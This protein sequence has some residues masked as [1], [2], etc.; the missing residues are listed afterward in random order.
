MK[1]AGHKTLESLSIYLHQTEQGRI[2]ATRAMERVGV[3]L[4]EFK[5]QQGARG[6]A[7]GIR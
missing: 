7:S 2:L 3:L 6:T 1:Y 5:G 4:G